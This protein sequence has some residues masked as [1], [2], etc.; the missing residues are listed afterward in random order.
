MA[1]YCKVIM[2]GNLTRDPELRFSAGGTA[3]AKLGLAVNHRYKK[4]DQNIEEVSF[5]DIVVFG[6][7]AEVCAD[8]LTKGRN[9][10]VEG[11]LRQNRWEKDGQKRS[12]VEVVAD[13][14]RFMG[15]G[16]GRAAESDAA[17][18]PSAEMEAGDQ[19]VAPA[20]GPEDE[21]PVDEDIPF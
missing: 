13:R 20:T 18:G 6:K 12:K 1:S 7:Q 21:A 8:Y 5:F 16:P 9:V 15:S 19:P 14:V 4:N 2:I 11:R 3:V 17:P 10:L